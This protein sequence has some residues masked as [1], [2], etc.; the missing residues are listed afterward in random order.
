LDEHVLVVAA[1][2]LF[3]DGEWLGFN[4]ELRAFRSLLANPKSLEYR[5]RSEVET[6]ASVKQLIPYAVIRRADE[7]FAYQR[8]KAGGENRLHDLWSIGVGGHICR[9]DGDSIE[10]AYRTGFLRELD[11]EVSIG[12]PFS[13]RIVG[14]LYDPRTPVG[15]VH[16]GVVHVVDVRG[17]V[18]SRDPS[19]IEAGFRPLE[20]LA[21]LAG[22]MESWSQFVIG[23]LAAGDFDR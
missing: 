7:I 23:P 16:V 9:E 2:I 13:D 3:A 4:R 17:E 12:G 11:E 6:D 1:D 5:P 8:G 21:A 20:S 18:T 22:S 10:D 14:L 19:L 15:T